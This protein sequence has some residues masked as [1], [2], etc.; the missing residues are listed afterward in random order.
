MTLHR[1]VTVALLTST[2][3]ACTEG[4]APRPAPGPQSPISRRDASLPQATSDPTVAADASPA[5]GYPP[6]PYGEMSPPVGSIVENLRL[7]GFVNP[8]G[9]GLAIEQPFREYSFA[10]LRSSGHRYAIV[11]TAAVW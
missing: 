10:E 3:V 11:L 4:R 5:D 7:R 9:K 8:T 1:T 2:L 6:G